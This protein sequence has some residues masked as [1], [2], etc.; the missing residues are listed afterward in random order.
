MSIEVDLS[1]DKIVLSE[2]EVGE[3]T[4]SPQDIASLIAFITIE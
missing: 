4:F 2:A 3:A 1:V